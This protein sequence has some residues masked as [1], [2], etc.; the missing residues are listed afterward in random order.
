MVCQKRL[1]SLIGGGSH[2]ITMMKI[3]VEEHGVLRGAES[4]LAADC[5]K[6][7]SGRVDQ[8]L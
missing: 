8:D 5:V 6:I 1:D 7:I 4:F 2:S 3:D